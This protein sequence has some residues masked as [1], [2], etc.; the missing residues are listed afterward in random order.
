MRIILTGLRPASC[1]PAIPRCNPAAMLAL[2]ACIH[3][4]P[5]AAA[6]IEA[7]AAPAG[8]SSPLPRLITEALRNNPEIRAARHERDASVQRVSPAG[9]LDD[10]MLEAGV[11]NVP[12]RSLSF[13]RE[14]MTMKMLGLSQRVPYPGKRELRR[15]VAEQDAQTAAH[16]YQETVNRVARETRVAYYEL[17]LALE[18][19]RLVERNRSTL[20]QLLKVAEGRYAVGRG[21]QVD[22]LKAQTQLSRMTEELI[23]LERERPALEAELIRLTGRPA[24]AGPPLPEPLRLDEAPLAFDA[25]HRQALEAR[26]QL[27]ALDSAVSRS[28]SALQLAA[29]DRYPDF[30]VRLSYG[31]RDGMPDGT[32]RADLVTLTVAMNLP[33]WRAA[34]TGPRVAEAQAMRDQALSVQQAQRNETAMKLRQQIATAEQS[35]RAARLYESEILPQSRLTAEAALAAYHAGR[36]DFAA[37]LDNQMAILGFEIGRAGAVAAYNKARAEIDLLTGRSPE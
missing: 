21:S 27:L 18:S 7:P 11:V 19:A 32:P 23:R 5:A 28:E 26:P 29:K 20:R 12:A 16:A 25:L 36:L 4:G 9:A 22:V 1:G 6:S 10:P 3:A 14:D 33:V 8:E 30:D 13:S 15:S 37:V 34:K 35:G 31:Q 17:A 24:A 2:A